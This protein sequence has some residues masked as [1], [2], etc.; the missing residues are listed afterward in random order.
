MKLRYFLRGLGVG[1][2][3]TAIILCVS[4]RSQG[5]PGGDVVEEA[6]K[7][8]MV[9][10]EGSQ[11]PE[12]NFTAAPATATPAVTTPAATVTPETT[13]KPEK[14]VVASGAGVTGET[15]GKT[16]KGTKFTVREGLLS[17]SVARE[18]KEAGIIKDD[19]AL[20]EY[21][22][23]SGYGRKVRSGTYYIP[24][25]ASYAEIARIITRQG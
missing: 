14:T 2:V 1:I 11:K 20:D 18:M 7:L 9:F 21:L 10:P 19:E 4:Y 25:G 23:K 24:K 5:T 6:K 8:G 12:D 15:T 13:K 17:S 22:E 3:L 16:K